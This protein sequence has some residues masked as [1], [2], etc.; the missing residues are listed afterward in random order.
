MVKK[1]MEFC[2][3]SDKENYGPPQKFCYTCQLEAAGDIV[4]R[5]G[6]GWSGVFDL[7]RARPCREGRSRRHGRRTG[8]ASAWGESHNASSLAAPLRRGRRWGIATSARERPTPKI[9]IDQRL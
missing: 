4:A 2:F 5:I 3:G 1:T 9:A 8:G 6:H 7:G